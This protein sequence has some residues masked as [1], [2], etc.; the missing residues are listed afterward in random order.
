MQKTY[1]VDGEFVSADAATIPVTDL[2]LVRGYGVFDFFRTYDGLP[3]QVERNVQRLRNS[4]RE[5]EMELPWTD[6]EIT[7]AV[8]DTLARN[9]FDEANIRIIVTGG[10]S[11][12]FIMPDDRPRLLVYVEPLKRLP[13]W[14]YTDGVKVVTVQEERYLP[15]SK[16]LNY[17]P[18]IIALKQARKAGAVEALYV[19]QNDNVRE[20]TTTN[21]FA[22]YDGGQVIT[23]KTDILPGVTRARVIEILERD[24]T[25]SEQTLAYDDLLAANEVVITAANKQIVPV[26]QVDAQSYGHGPGP[27]SRRLMQHFSDYVAQQ[28]AL[29][30]QAAGF[31]GGS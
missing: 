6:E 11:P 8:M 19:D 26:V 28:I 3:I 7:A 29:R 1:Y 12:D 20:G 9:D 18:A 27:L 31:G 4:A 13:E 25:V 5:I 16:S 24:Y 15:R 30:P 2:A 22:F 17:I 21:L 10:D 23:P 14:W